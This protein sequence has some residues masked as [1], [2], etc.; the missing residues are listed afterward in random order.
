M[1]KLLFFLG[2]YKTFPT[3]YS[4]RFL[5]SFAL[6]I[7]PVFQLFSQQLELKGKILEENSKITVI[8]AS[9]KVKNQQG[10]TVTD[11]NGNFSLKVKSFPVTLGITSIGYKN[12][13]I[14]VY[15]NEP[16]TIYLTENSNNLSEVVVVGYGTQKRKELTGA[17]ATVSKSQLE[18]NIAPSVDALLSGAV[19]GVNVTQGSGQPGSPASIRIRGGNSINA[20]NDPL[21][22]IDGFLYFSDNSS[23]KLGIKGIEGESNPLNLLNA[24]DIESIEVLKDVSATAIYGSRG[25]N[26]VIQ[27]TTKK[28]KKGKNSV[29][30]QFSTG[31]SQ[32]AK[33]LDL[34]NASQWARL[35][36]DYFL[37]KPGYTDAEIDKL[38]TGYDWQGAVL[39][40]GITQTHSISISGG[41]DKSQY[42]ISGNYLN[43]Q[44]IIINSGFER[45]TGKFNYDKEIFSGFKIGINLTGNKSTQDGLTTFEG[46]NYNSSPFSKGI[47]NSLTYALYIP[48]VVSIYN[49][50]GSYNYSNPYEYAYL[51]EGSKTANP[52]SDLNNSVSQTVNTTFLG[53]F[54]AQLE[55]L[56]G[57]TAKLNLGTNLNYTTQ[58]YFAPEYTALGLEP[59]GVGGIGNKK[60]QISLTEFTLAYTK[61]IGIH[62]LD[63]LTGVTYE[64]SK[65]NYMSGTTSGFTDATL[66]V[67][68]LQDGSPYGNT[69]ISSGISSSE[70]YSV[71][72]RIN[73]N[74]LKRYNL[75]TSFRYDYSSRLAVSHRGN[76]YPSIGLS[77]NAN[78]EGFL[79]SIS[80]I[81][82]LK[83][84]ASI[85]KVGNQEIPDNV[86]DQIVGVAK[87]NGQTA[88]KIVNSGN[89]NLKWETTTQYNIGVDAG[90]LNNRISA[91]LDAYY[92]KTTDLLLLIPPTLGNENKQLVN[93]GNVVNKG[94]EFSVNVQIIDKKKFNWSVTANIAKNRNEITKLADNGDII[95]GV[96]ILRVGESLGSFYGLKFDGVTQKNE[97][98]TKLPT[99]PAYTTPKPGDPKFI[100]ASKDGHIG[101]DDRVV[102]G[103]IQPDF[104]YGFSSTLKYHGFDLFVLLQ[105][106]HGNKVYNQLRRFLESPT[107][108]YNV[109]SVLLNAWTETN[110]SNTVPRITNVPLS[111][112]LDSRYVEDASYLRLKTVTLGYTLNKIAF[113]ASK[114][115]L[116]LRVYATIQN[117]FTITGYKGYD[118]EVAKGVDLGSYPMA[119]TILVGVNISL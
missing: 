5:T 97:D 48:P 77:W 28:G 7:L 67:N 3:L 72:G 70:L 57:L 25:S 92:K 13:E 18:Y 47:A 4:Q 12:Q 114:I 99:T 10:G 58:N 36:K 69:P 83:L 39:Q 90:I 63:I 82:S 27:I 23:T 21:Y 44:G 22:V 81:N 34:L 95:D 104:T 112:E 37:N 100:D 32:S 49:S 101:S 15:D 6:V 116:N 84:R 103:S 60:V 33:K 80:E 76:F 53:N 20:S 64:D 41:D 38:G 11:V 42:F 2:N 52:V 66:G 108:A 54:Y 87:Y 26:G 16:V 24:S 88:Y 62:S 31:L 71:L 14:D 40:S 19:A 96:N 86:F 117:L 113:V 78:E 30:Y 106:T 102:L 94:I 118:P 107:D 8:G 55:I 110:P 1:T 45:F 51:R 46:V 93:V 119:R 50:N 105:G 56:K 9:I 91:T 115:P 73:Y 65:S 79:K 98:V 74:L 17:I 111:S 43:Q 59:N 109:S 89:P 75:T 85:G 61:Q 29:N 35:Q 68:N